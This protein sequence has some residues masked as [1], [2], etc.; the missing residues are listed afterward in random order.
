MEKDIIVNEHRMEEPNFKL[1]LEKGNPIIIA[2]NLIK[3][4][5]YL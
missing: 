2:K 3:D 4:Y 5:E 1:E